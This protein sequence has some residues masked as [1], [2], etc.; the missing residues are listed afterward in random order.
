MCFL[1][2]RIPKG[3]LSYF[4]KVRI[5]KELVN[6]ELW[7]VSSRRNE[8]RSGRVAPPVFCKRVRKPLTLKELTKC[9][10]LESGEEC[11]NRGVS[12]GFF[13]KRVEARC[14]MSGERK[15]RITPRQGRG[16][17]P[18]RR[19]E[20]DAGRGWHP[21][22]TVYVTATRDNFSRYF[23]YSN[24]SNGARMGRKLIRGRGMGGNLVRE[25]GVCVRRG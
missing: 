3:L 14:G 6:S 13:C 7:I 18:F 12:F 16:R 22:F 10:F 5:L 9:S 24:D 25:N 17:R 19:E 2:L 4:S 1:K 23:L 21:M 15:K 8:R 20:G 11:E